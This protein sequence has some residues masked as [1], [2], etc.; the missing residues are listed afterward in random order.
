[1]CSSD[2]ASND[3][4]GGSR[5]EQELWAVARH[6]IVTGFSESIAERCSEEDD[7]SGAEQSMEHLA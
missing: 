3:E 2:V 7:G 6:I 1:M 4:A 5:A